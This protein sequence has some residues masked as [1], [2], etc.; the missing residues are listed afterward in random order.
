MDIIDKLKR[1][2]IKVLDIPKW[3]PFFQHS[4]FALLLENAST[5]HT[6]DLIDEIGTDMYI[7]DKQFRWTFVLT[8]ET[9]WLGPYFSRN[10]A[11]GN[12]QARI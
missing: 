4:D 10:Q 8:H 3:G 12:Q 7:V 6:D 1:K 11:P 9:G 2:N 5:F